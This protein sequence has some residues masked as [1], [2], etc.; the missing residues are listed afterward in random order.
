V[1][2]RWRSL[3]S[4][5]HSTFPPRRYGSGPRGLSEPERAGHLSGGSRNRKDAL[6]G[7]IGGSF[8]SAEK[9]SAFRD[10][11]AVVNAL[12]ETKNTESADDV[13]AV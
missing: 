6:G 12:R 3:T 13:A 5:R 9:A 2:I 4:A 7:G 1:R 11:S 10:G 8:L